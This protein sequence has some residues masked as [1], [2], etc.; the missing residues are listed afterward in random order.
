MDLQEFRETILNTLDKRVT[1][2]WRSDLGV[3]S[4]SWAQLSE[5]SMNILEFMIVRLVEAVYLHGK[6]KSLIVEQIKKNWK[7]ITKENQENQ[8]LPEIAKPF[9][10]SLHGPLGTEIRRDLIIN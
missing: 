6:E 4:N 10:Q 3:I 5:K 1:S 9:I 8:Q 7:I 2:V